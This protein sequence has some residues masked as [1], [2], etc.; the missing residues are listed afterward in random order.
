MPTLRFLPLLALI[1]ACDNGPASDP[2]QLAGGRQFGYAASTASGAP[3]LIGSLSLR[4]SDEGP[5]GGIVV[6]TWN[7]GWA[8]GADT[9]LKIGP[10]LG[11]GQ[12]VGT[13]D[14]GGVLLDLNPGSKFEYVRL[15][16]RVAKG[17]MYGD[18]EWTQ[19]VGPGSSGNF[20]AARMRCYVEA[21]ASHP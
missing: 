19:V 3:L 2:L 7:I 15:S 6:G 10:Q 1:V 21:C 8:P 20:H 17:A 16:A 4:W 18:W 14:E 12:L 11:S 9:T 5:D 13:V